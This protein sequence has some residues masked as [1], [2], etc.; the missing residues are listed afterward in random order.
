[1]CTGRKALAVYYNCNIGYDTRRVQTRSKYRAQKLV[2]TPPCWRWPSTSNGT[3][4]C[5]PCTCCCSFGSLPRC[6]PLGLAKLHMV[7]SQVGVD[8]R[9]PQPIRSPHALQ[10]PVPAASQPHTQHCQRYCKNAG[11]DYIGKGAMPWVFIQAGTP[12]RIT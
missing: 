2:P 7:F 5:S 8:W 3:A 11:D 4:L 12:I 6:P 1:M 9:V 10:L